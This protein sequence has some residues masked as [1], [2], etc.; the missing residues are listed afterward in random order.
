MNTLAKTIECG[1]IF[2]N[3]H[4]ETFVK[5]GKSTGGETSIA[6]SWKWNGNN[7]EIKLNSK[8]T[9]Y[10]IWYD[11]REIMDDMERWKLYGKHGSEN[12]VK[13]GRKMV[14]VRMVMEEGN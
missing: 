7:T 13:P 12:G 2:S 4:T 5:V 14:M 3:C 10:Y 1:L 8:N 6:P 11:L 9:K